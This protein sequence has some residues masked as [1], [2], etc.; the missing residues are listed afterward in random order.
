MPGA[1]DLRFAVAFLSASGLSLIEP[2]LRRSFI[3]GGRV[4]FLVGLD[5]LT[6]EPDALRM[7]NDMT[8]AGL[9]ITCYCYSDPFTHAAPMYHPKLY[10]MA[11]SEQITAVVGSSNLTRGGLKDNVE[12]NTVI[13]ADANDET[14]SDVYAVY[15]KLKFEQPRVQPD[16][17]FVRLYEALH[18]NARR[19]TK[20][21]LSDVE[22]RQLKRQLATK[23]ESLRR[24][25]PTAADL[26]GW[27][28][29]VFERLP[30]GAFR[31]SD[32]YGFERDFQRYYP[33]NKNIRPKIRQILQQLRGLGLLRHVATNVWEKADG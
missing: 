19:K 4:E 29:L 15:N 33:D 18:V 1:S 8:Q 2:C 26:F 28:R 23:I 13:L 7:L 32:L 20:A 11:N 25:T 3:A 27:Q 9:P 5:F 14:I 31:P 24:P 22:T 6:T 30:D 16:G 17:E 10:L 12:V 21:A